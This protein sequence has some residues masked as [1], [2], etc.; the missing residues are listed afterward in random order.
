[1]EFGPHW[2]SESIPRCKG[3]ATETSVQLAQIAVRK[4]FQRIPERLVRNRC[5][6]RQLRAAMPP[7]TPVQA[8]ST[9]QDYSVRPQELEISLRL[10]DDLLCSSRP[11]R[12]PSPKNKAPAP[13]SIS[14]GPTQS[15]HPAAPQTQQRNSEASPFQNCTAVLLQLHPTQAYPL[16]MDLERD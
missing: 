2:H 11:V 9:L 16:P 13:Q 3:P 4:T 7:Y 10:K 1:M 8:P 12:T 15:D 14:A 6:R 5:T